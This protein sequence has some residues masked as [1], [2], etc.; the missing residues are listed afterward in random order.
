LRL[1][2]RSLAPSAFA[3][4]LTFSSLAGAEEEAST[5]GPPQA[6]DADLATARLHFANGVEL[7]QAESPNY[8][9]AYQQFILALE[10]SGRSWKVLGNLALCALKLERDGEALAY[11]DEYLERGGDEIDPRERASIQKETLLAR[12]NL[13]TLNIRSSDPNARITVSRQG[14][15][16]PS[17]LYDLDKDGHA[18]LGLRSG[19]ITVVARAGE[20]R[21][22]WTSAL[23][24]GEQ[25]THEFDFEASKEQASA[26]SAATSSSSTDS[27]V[28]RRPSG[29]FIAGLATAG[30][31][32]LTVGGG[33]VLGVMSQNKESSA[34][35]SCIESTCPEST[36]ADFDSAASMATAA[37]VMF[38]AGGVLAATGITLAVLGTRSK[39]TEG[40][41]A[42][43]H[44]SVAPSVTPAG[45][46]LF[47]YGTF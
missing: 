9:D 44:L 15:S 32:V 4:F 41:V 30:V 45:G 18:T 19:T 17:Q 47:A 7:L 26:P 1:I 28:K 34:R 10:K 11:Y 3:L 24:P 40:A 43:R 35:D 27:G 25:T 22:E 46:G 37:N 8:Q 42:A 21:L 13:T 31:G 33:A 5:A 16:A 36:E 38:I 6:S 29:L 12:G 2:R 23:S 39:K 14:S 20:K